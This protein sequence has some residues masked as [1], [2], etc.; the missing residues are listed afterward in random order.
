MLIATY[1][2]TFKM[3]STDS[4]QKIIK[5]SLGIMVQILYPRTNILI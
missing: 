2:L 3:F 5:M 1:I 4:S